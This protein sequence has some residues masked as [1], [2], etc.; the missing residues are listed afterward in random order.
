MPKITGEPII[1]AH[2]ERAVK[3]K[4]LEIMSFGVTCMV[5]KEL[6]YAEPGFMQMLKGYV[7]SDW[8]NQA[9]RIA[10]KWYCPAEMKREI[11][12]P[13]NWIEAIKER[14]AP[15][16]LKARWPV[17][18]RVVRVYEMFPEYEWPA[19]EGHKRNVMIYGSI[20]A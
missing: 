11:K 17:E 14:F 8:P 9:I 20:D 18:Y 7:E 15:E 16:W 19:Y 1:P 3:Q 10:A 6:H 12:W 13:A 5:C 4:T 2:I